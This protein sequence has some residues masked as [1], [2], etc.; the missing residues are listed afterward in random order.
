M[1]LTD[2][3]IGFN[4]GLDQFSGN[5]FVFFADFS[6]LHPSQQSLTIHLFLKF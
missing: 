4:C 3:E 2:D 1:V 6:L 5:I